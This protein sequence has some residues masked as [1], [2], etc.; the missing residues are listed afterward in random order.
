MYD[1]NLG[2]R[3]KDVEIV[4]FFQ[5]SQT[6]CRMGFDIRRNSVGNLMLQSWTTHLSQLHSAAPF[7][8]WAA[9]LH[10]GM[11]TRIHMLLG[12]V[13]ILSNLERLPS[14]ALRIAFSTDT[15]YVCQCTLVRWFPT[16]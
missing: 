2:R 15:T 8:S 16:F 9:L 5:T 6:R 10:S 14:I 4:R 7:L 13:R 11:H 1:R 12:F 3:S